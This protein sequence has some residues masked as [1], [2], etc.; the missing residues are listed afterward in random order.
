M[1][2]LVKDKSEL[3]DFVLNQNIDLSYLDTSLITDM[4]E[5]F[6]N[7]NRKDFSGINTWDTSNVT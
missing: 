6:L 7:S 5:L 2:I 3:I 4:S 1:K